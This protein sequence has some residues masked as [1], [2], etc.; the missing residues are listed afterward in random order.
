MTDSGSRSIEER[1][2]LV[3]RSIL[4]GALGIVEGCRKLDGLRGRLPEAEADREIFDDIVLLCSETEIYP[5]GELRSMWWPDALERIDRQVGRYVDQM[6]E[7]IMDTCTRLIEKYSAPAPT[8][9]VGDS[10]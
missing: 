1:I 3:A 7:P 9:D 5:V 8:D 4:S 6:R 10:P 2:V